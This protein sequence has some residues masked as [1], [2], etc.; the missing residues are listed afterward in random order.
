MQCKSHERGSL[1]DDAGKLLSGILEKHVQKLGG[2]FDRS[3]DEV[4]DGLPTF[5]RGRYRIGRNS[6]G[7]HFAG[8][9]FDL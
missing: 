5:S 6:E 4:I 8:S 3:V 2:S 9:E 7:G 1:G